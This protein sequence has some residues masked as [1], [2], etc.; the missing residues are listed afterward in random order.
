MLRRF[1]GVCGNAIWS[2]VADGTCYVKA[3][4]IP[5]ALHKQPTMAIYQQNLPAWSADIKTDK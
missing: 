4:V 5:G 2:Q 1:C 3:P